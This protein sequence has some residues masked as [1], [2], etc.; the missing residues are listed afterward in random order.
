MVSGLK[1]HH[2]VAWSLHEYLLNSKLKWVNACN[3]TLQMITGLFV[4]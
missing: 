2:I 3:I 4:N 1:S